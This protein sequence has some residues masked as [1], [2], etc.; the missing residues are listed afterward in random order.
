MTELEKLKD[1]VTLGAKRFE[2]RPFLVDGKRT[3]SFRD[4]Q[5]STFSVAVVMRQQGLT[6][7]DRIIFC[8]RNSIDMITNIFAAIEL[9]CCFSIIHP[10]SA[11]DSVEYIAQKLGATY[12]IGKKFSNQSCRHIELIRSESL[13]TRHHEGTIEATAPLDILH[14]SLS[15]SDELTSV[16]FTSG[17]TGNFPKGIMLSHRNFLFSA[18]AIQ[19]VLKYESSDVIGLFMPLSFDVG[20]YQILLCLLAGSSLFVSDPE[21]IDIRLLSLLEASKVSVLPGTPYL[22]SILDRVLKRFSG[23]NRSLALRLITNTGEH[24]SEK[25]Q[26]DLKA[27]IPGLEINLMYGLSECKRVSILPVADYENFKHTVGL[28]LPMT[29]VLRPA[30]VD[31][32]VFELIVHGPHVALGYL[33][34]DSEQFFREPNL[35]YRVLRTGDLVRLIEGRYL[36]FV[37]RNNQMIKHKGFR[38]NPLEIENVIE[39]I[40]PGSVA[41]LVAHDSGRLILFLAF[42]R[43]ISLADLSHLC[44]DRIDKFKM[45]D[46]VVM[47]HEIPRSSNGKKDRKALAR[48]SEKRSFRYA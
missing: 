13:V 33:G 30:H 31:S 28:P 41:C 42:D 16:L 34:E 47:C 27:G 44:C 39:S 22:F 9:G 25:L 4:F 29:D 18:A 8:G 10:D 38:L 20:F 36:Q 26:H 11:L 7:N 45:P 37:G 15:A 14:Q 23:E 46:S 17:T 2:D 40:L 5:E 32:E 1:L 35:P 21:D 43:T 24:I 19:S 12:L 48:W 3:L 6:D